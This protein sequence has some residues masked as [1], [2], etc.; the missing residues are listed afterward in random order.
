MSAARVEDLALAEAAAVLAGRRIMEAFGRDQTVTMKAPGQPV[1]E[2]DLAADAIL[3]ECLLADRPDYGWLSEESAASPDR[4]DR[5]RVWIVDPIDGTRSFVAARPEFSI[6]IGLAE[7]GVAVLGLVANPATGEVFTA[8]RGGGAWCTRPGSARTRLSVSA[9]P[10]AEGG[11]LLGSRSELARGRFDALGWEVSPLGSTAY[12]L[13]RVAAGQG[14]AFVSFGPKSEWDVCAGMLMVEEAGGRATDGAG[15][16]PAY[17]R[18]EPH[19]RGVVAGSVGAWERIMER[20][21]AQ[22]D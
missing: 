18:P 12:K 9:A 16:V 7:D 19:L 5:R 3:R 1:T 2:A 22:V 11:I 13:A 17:N 10:A 21:R 20:I 4:A 15:N 6:S 14:D 8:V